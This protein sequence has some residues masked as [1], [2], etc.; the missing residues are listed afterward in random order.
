MEKKKINAS[1]VHIFWKSI[2]EHQQQYGKVQSQFRKCSPC[3]LTFGGLHGSDDKLES[4]VDF[5]L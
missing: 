4:L 2:L 1:T 3:P 5:R